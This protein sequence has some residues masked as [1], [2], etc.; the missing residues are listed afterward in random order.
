MDRFERFRQGHFVDVSLTFYIFHSAQVHPA[1][2]KYKANA[3]SFLTHG[4]IPG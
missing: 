1:A 4:Y 3:Q 2:V